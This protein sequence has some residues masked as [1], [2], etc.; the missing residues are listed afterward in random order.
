MDFFIFIKN[1]TIYIN[2]AVVPCDKL[3]RCLGC[4][5]LRDSTSIGFSKVMI[6]RDKL[7]ASPLTTNK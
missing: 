6:V 5:H 2:P 7:T 3:T 4:I 1:I